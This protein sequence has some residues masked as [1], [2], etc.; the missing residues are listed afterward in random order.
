[1]HDTC[2]IHDMQSDAKLKICSKP[3]RPRHVD[4]KFC[5]APPGSYGHQIGIMVGIRVFEV[6][7]NNKSRIELGWTC[8]PYWTL[9]TT[10]DGPSYAMLVIGRN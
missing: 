2:M 9:A 5:V 3:Q 4:Q 1:M 10:Y 8:R 7:E 6:F